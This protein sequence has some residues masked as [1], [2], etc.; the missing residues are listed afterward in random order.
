MDTDVSKNLFASTFR[1][2]KME[3]T[4][5]WYLHTLLHDITAQTAK[6]SS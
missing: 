5:R 4:R 3:A 6:L 1:V 2:E